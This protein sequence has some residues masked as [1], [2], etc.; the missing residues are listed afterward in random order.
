MPL[1]KPS[2]QVRVGSLSEVE[3]A[4]EAAV[5][6]L[7]MDAPPEAL[8]RAVV[9]ILRRTGG[10]EG[11]AAP[12][13]APSPQA[14][15]ARGTGQR[16]PASPSVRPKVKPEEH[17]VLL[18]TGP[19]VGFLLPSREQGN[20][21]SY[22]P[23]AD[24]RPAK[25]APGPGLCQRLVLTVAGQLTE[26]KERELRAY[27]EKNGCRLVGWEREQVGEMAV[28]IG[29]VDACSCRLPFVELKRQLEDLGVRLGLLVGLQ[30]E[31]LFNYIHRL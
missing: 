11:K 16:A 6:E 7:G 8:T 13:P 21:F 10:E 1:A 4:I 14:Q 2:G 3:G 23:R 19:Q 28:V 9:E 18:H 12:K 29:R 27:L 31:E 5:R 24:Y 20:A 15:A 30:S 26:P 25:A 17:P 22:Q